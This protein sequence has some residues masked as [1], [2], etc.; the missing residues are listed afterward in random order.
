MHPTLVTR[1]TK[2]NRPRRP[3][4]GEPLP[5]DLA[6]WAGLLVLGGSMGSHDDAACPWLPA[7][8]RWAALVHGHAAARSAAQ[9][10]KSSART[11]TTS[12]Q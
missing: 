7:A 4:A 9:V 12:A 2:G 6:G 11:A 3:D 5:E 8:E 10:P 1:P